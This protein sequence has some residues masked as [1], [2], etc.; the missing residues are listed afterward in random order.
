VQPFYK[1]TQLAKKKKKSPPYTESERP[2][3]CITDGPYSET[4]VS[5]PRPLL[6]YLLTSGSRVLL[7]KLT[8][9]QLVLWNP[10]VH[11][12]SHK[13][14]PPLPTLS[15][16]DPFR[17]P[18]SHFVKI[19]LNI[20]FPTTPGCPK[21]LLFNS[22]RNNSLL[23]TPM[24]FKWSFIRNLWINI[25]NTGR[26]VMF[27]AITNIYNKKTKGPPLMEL[28]TATWK[29]KLLQW[30]VPKGTDHCSEEYRCTHVDACVARTWISYRCV[31]CHPWCTHRTSLVVKKS[32]SFPVVVNNSIKVG[33]FV[34]LL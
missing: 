10:K 3:P 16:L 27:S 15:Q 28:F 33:P 6:I 25:I 11:Y 32:F 7:E 29:L 13:C 14:P 18:T 24:S 23:F 4:S 31:P 26:F 2:S 21:W 1:T 19:H 30:P 17:T 22:H 34:F 5:S 8:S 12:R 20:I 9:F